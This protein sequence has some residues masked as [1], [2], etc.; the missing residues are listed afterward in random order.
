[1]KAFDNA[2]QG[3]WRGLR[4]DSRAS[5]FFA[6]SPYGSTGNVTNH[7][8]SELR[9]RSCGHMLSK[10]REIEYLAASAEASVAVCPDSKLSKKRENMGRWRV[11]SAIPMTQIS[12][13]A[14][15]YE[16]WPQKKSERSRK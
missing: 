4:S 13:L 3:T 10:G 2:C 7:I 14:R 9:G 11:D 1:M 5:S 16:R 12:V 15:I 6:T 8:R